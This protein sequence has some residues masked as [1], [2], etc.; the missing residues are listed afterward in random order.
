MDNPQTA[1][2]DDTLNLHLKEREALQNEL[3][4]AEASLEADFVNY[5]SNGGAVFM[6]W[7]DN[8]A[9]GFAQCGFRHDYVE[10]TETSPV[11]YLEGVFIEVDYRRQGIARELVRACQIFAK[12]QG[13]TE[14]A[15]DCELDNEESLQFHLKMGFE[16]ANRIICFTKKL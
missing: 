7:N 2:S 9:I 8:T 10:G 15:S 14:F 13:C 5:M 16:E 4:Q 6:A 11:G 1:L 12:E 3:A